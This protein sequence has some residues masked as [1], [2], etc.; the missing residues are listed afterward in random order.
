MKSGEHLTSLASGRGGSI[1]RRAK[2]PA[3]HRLPSWAPASSKR[4]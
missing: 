3:I 4:Q 1:R 2:T